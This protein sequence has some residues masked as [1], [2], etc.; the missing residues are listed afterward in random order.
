MAGPVTL[1]MGE[2]R[3]QAPVGSAP[4]LADPRS[5]PEFRAAYSDRTSALMAQLALI[6]YAT[7]PYEDPKT[8]KATGLIPKTWSEAP[9]SLKALGVE[10]V[11]YFFNQRVD[12][13]AYIAVSDAM[14]VLSFRGTQSWGNW[15]TN[16]FAL[17][18]PVFGDGATRQLLVHEG[19]YEA[20]KDMLADD[21]HFEAVFRQ[22]M[23]DR[24][25][26]PAF[27]TG[28][29]LGGALAQIGAARLEVVVDQ[30]FHGSPT[31]PSDRIAACYTY[32]SPR[33]GNMYFDLWVKS[34]SYRVID[35]ADMV[36]MVPFWWPYR[37]SGDAR[38]MPDTV[39]DS[40]FRYQPTSLV[41]FLHFLLGFPVLALT[42]KILGIQDHM[43]GLYVKKL[44]KIAGKLAKIASDRTSQRR[45]GAA[46][47]PSA[48]A[49]PAKKPS[50]PPS[51]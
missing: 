15:K 42:G 29:S 37:H 45:A 9:P 8:R 7:T 47:Q 26:T 27:V 10:Q 36:P 43:P 25:N 28:H 49:F 46:Q 13:W 14:I 2:P 51:P 19:F 21:A 18:T 34:P 12:G 50:N 22:A 31:P 33:V 6:A 3:A 5:L 16:L 17:L 41:N 30:G 1:A 32:G 44:E 38:Y 20:Y 48:G 23:L 40:P 11:M 39:K 24:P 35:Y 4:G